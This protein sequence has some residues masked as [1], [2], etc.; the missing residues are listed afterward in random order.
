MKYE[1]SFYVC[2]TIN[3]EINYEHIIRYS[4]C[5]NLA[6]LKVIGFQSCQGLQQV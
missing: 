5:R 1:L 4:G 6:E 3:F 2:Y